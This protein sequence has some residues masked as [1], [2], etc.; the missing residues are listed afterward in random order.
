MKEYEN[1]DDTEQYI[2]NLEK[3]NNRLYDENQQLQAT[4]EFLKLEI[5]KLKENS[6]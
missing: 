5:D 6:K 4:I 3:D 1:F 2:V